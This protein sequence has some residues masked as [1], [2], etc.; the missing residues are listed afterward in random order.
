MRESRK[1]EKRIKRMNNIQL[2]RIRI[3]RG[4]GSKKTG[5]VPRKDYGD[6]YKTYICRI[7]RRVC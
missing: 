4:K 6:Q 5:E 3:I 7:P 2:E 1:K